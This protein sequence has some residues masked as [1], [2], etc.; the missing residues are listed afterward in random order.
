ML[1][2]K[3]YNIKENLLLAYEDYFEESFSLRE[4]KF[5]NNETSYDNEEWTK[6]GNKL[7]TYFLDNELLIKVDLI[8]DGQTRHVKFSYFNGK[9]FTYKMRYDLD[10][11]LS[12][13]NKIMFIV[14]KAIEKFEIEQLGFG[15]HESNEKLKPVYGKMITNKSFLRM[16]KTKSFSYKGEQEGIYIFSKTKGL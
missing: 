14:S 6:T 10:S 8:N 16:M 9:T 7:T 2:F 11:S 4:T 12:L 5:G 13:F 3:E 1:S 15:A